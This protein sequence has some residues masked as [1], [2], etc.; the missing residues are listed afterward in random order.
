VTT[1]GR[2]PYPAQHVKGILLVRFEENVLGAEENV[3]RLEMGRHNSVSP[4]RSGVLLV[5]SKLSF[6]IETN[7]MRN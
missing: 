5:N 6:R 4:V 1:Q 2:G 7:Q 3:E